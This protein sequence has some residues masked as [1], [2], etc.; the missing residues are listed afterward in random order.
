MCSGATTTI[1]KKIIPNITGKYRIKPQE[2]YAMETY[3]ENK[4]W[5]TFKLNNA[6]YCI[7]SE[8]VDSIVIPEKITEMPGNPPYLLGVTNYNH[9]TIPVVEMR[10]L[11]NMMNLTEY[12]NRFAEMKQMHVDWIE[13]LEEAVEKRVTF[14]KAVDPHKCKFGIWY[15]QFHTDNISLNFVLKKIAAPHEFIHCCGGEINQLMARKEWE[16]AEKRLEDAKR[17]CYNEVIPLLDQLIET[18]KEVNRGVVIV[19]NRNNQYTGIM[20]DEITTLVAYSKTELQ[21]IPSGVERSEYVDF[22]VLYDS[23]TMMGVDAERI[24]DITVSEEEKEQLREAALA[25]NAG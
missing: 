22:I 15:D 8:F 16:A 25:E 9:R 20:V 7:T 24:L 12:V 23:K 1:I 2:G 11:F 10:T 18:Y 21:S 13:A 6:D 3:D 17:T 14:T 19:L 4:L 5:V